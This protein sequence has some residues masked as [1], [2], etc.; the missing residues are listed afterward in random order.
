[1]NEREFSKTER[2]NKRNRTLRKKKRCIRKRES[3]N[4]FENS[5]ILLIKRK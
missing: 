5:S 3:K 1:M 4:S 2:K